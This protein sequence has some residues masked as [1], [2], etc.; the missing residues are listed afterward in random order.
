MNLALFLHFPLAHPRGCPPKDR[1]APGR[2]GQCL[3][4]VGSRTKPPGSSPGFTNWATYLASLCLC[5][6]ICKV[7]TM[8]CE[9]IYSEFL[10]EDPACGV[11]LKRAG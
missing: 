8:S 11:Y 1:R 6:I 4:H 7:G 3:K 2:Q 5:F 10:E 9:E